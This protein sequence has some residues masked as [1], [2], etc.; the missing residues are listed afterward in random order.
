MSETSFPN[1]DDKGILCMNFIWD[2]VFSSLYLSINWETTAMAQIVST[3]MVS[4]YLTNQFNFDHIKVYL[5]MF[6]FLVLTVKAT[7][8]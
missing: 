4:K 7:M 1:P 2:F 6:S 3:V 5:T 8:D